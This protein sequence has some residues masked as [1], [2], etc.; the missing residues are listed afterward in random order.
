MNMAARMFSFGSQAQ[1][2]PADVRLINRVALIL[3]MLAC[4]VGLA[5]FV[6]WAL[7]QPVFA[8]TRIVVDGDTSHHNAIT[9]KANVGGRITGNFFT[10]DLA[11]TRQVF[12][13]VPW[14]RQATVRREFPNRL[15]VTLQEH[16]SVAFWGADTESRMVNT[17]GEVF[18]ANAD[19]AQADEL[20]RLVAAEGQSAHALTMYRQLSAV[21]QALDLTIDQLEFS[22]RGDWRITLDNGA[23]IELGRGQMQEVIAR[24]QT[25]VNTQAQVFAAYQRLSLDRVESVDLRHNNG[26]AIRLSGVSTLTTSD[27]R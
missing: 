24:L 1:S 4:A 17:R 12:E 16:R 27:Q 5:S 3:G 13:S 11:Q 25:F 26:Y 14:V 20:P 19:D 2:L 23:S 22:S 7:A 18:E 9:L 15:R 6:K 21:M 8:I 10:L